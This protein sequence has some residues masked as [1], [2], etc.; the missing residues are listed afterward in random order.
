MHTASRRSTGSLIGFHDR[1]AGVHVRIAWSMTP[2]TTYARICEQRDFVAI[3]SPIDR[4]LDS[5]DVALHAT[6]QRRKVQGHLAG[7]TVRGSHIPHM[8][9]GIPVDWRFEHE[10]ID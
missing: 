3:F 9:V 7:A 2:V 1:A 6:Y 8:P 5:A 10:G 4:R